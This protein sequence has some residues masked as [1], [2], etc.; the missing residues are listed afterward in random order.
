MEEKDA[1]VVGAR[2]AGST[3]ALALAQRGWDVLVVDRDTFPSETVSTHFIYPNSLARFEQLGVLDT[4]RA[5]HEVPLLDY[6][7]IGLGHEIAGAFTPVDGFD[8]AAAP[9]RSVLDKAIVDTALAAGA[10]G[11]F[12]E[13]VVG[14][15]GSGTAE[16]PVAGVVL[17]SGE[18]ISARWVIGADGRGSTVAGR[19]GLPKERPLSGEMSFLFA[20]WSG[21]PDNGYA[22]LDIREDESANRWAV[23]DGLHLLIAA[24]N[25][26][27]TRGSKDERQRRYLELLRRFPE[28][29][30]PDV[31]GRAQMASE[32]IVAPESLMRGFFRSPT[33]PGWA[34][35]GDACHFKHPATAQG[36]ADAVEQALYVAEALAD[37]EP[38][39]DGYEEWRDKRALEHYEWSFS[40]GR[41][42]RPELEPLFRGWM[43]E[44]DAGQDLR[45]SFSRRVEPSRVLS[46]ERLARWFGAQPEAEAAH[47]S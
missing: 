30:E 6:R 22:T 44:A 20:Y 19:L 35:V 36:I 3:L 33:G 25:A 32:L 24:G 34:L 21:I 23:E 26:E 14:L 28:T 8:K 42:P 40:W 43:S 31:L 4:L 29:I 16:D 38:G 17:E 47:S 1:V 37:R 45:D 27:F 41:F 12:G 2:C 11:R 5:A 13:R 46:K 10:E 15:I 18:R 9:R 39:L 7:I